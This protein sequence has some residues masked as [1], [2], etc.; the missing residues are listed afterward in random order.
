MAILNQK[1]ETR[2]SYNVNLGIVIKAWLME[3]EELKVLITL[4]LTK[5]QAKVYLACC[6]LNQA[7]VKSISI[8]GGIARSEVYRAIIGLQ[9]IGMMEKVFANP[10][11]FRIVPLTSSIP[12]L[13]RKR[14]QEI[15]CAEQQAR[16]L[17]RLN[18]NQI[19]VS[20]TDD[21]TIYVSKT[22]S[23]LPQIRQ[24]TQNCSSS[25]DIIGDFSRALDYEKY[26]IL[27][28]LHKENIKAAKRGVKIR[29]I[30]EDPRDGSPI[31]ES[32]KQIWQG[33]PIQIKHT[34]EGFA[35][36]LAI[37]DAREFHVFISET[38]DF[39]QASLIYSNNPRLVKLLSYYFE[40]LWKIAKDI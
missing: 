34:R 26:D 25:L 22:E 16:R 4:G 17:I 7:S 40:N 12:M 14:K 19:N 18:Q 30:V 28:F 6:K 1:A 33:Q 11:E 36:P 9:K 38:T 2:K 39:L 8:S 29:L 37:Y 32:I 10:I 5:L 20:E 35:A 23:Y 27:D 21:K 24:S 13:L 3:N 15:R 31:P